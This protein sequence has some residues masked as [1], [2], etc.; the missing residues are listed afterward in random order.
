MAIH[1]NDSYLKGVI[2]E[3]EYKGLAPLVKTCHEELHQKT[4][5]GNDFLGWIDL[6][7]DYDKEEFARIKAAAKRINEQ[8]DILIVL[9]IGGSYLGARAAIELLRSPF[10]NSLKKDTVDIYFAGNSVSATYLQELL[11]ICEGKDLAVN[12]VSKSGTTTETA[13]AF[14]IFKQLLEEKYGVEGAKSRIYCTTDKANGKL[15][16][17]ADENGY[18][19]F[20]IPDDAGGRFSVLTAVGLLPIAAAGCDLDAIMKGAADARKDFLEPDLEKNDCY[21]YAATRFALYQKQKKMEIMVS[22]EPCFATMA[23]WYKQLFGESEGKDNKGLYPSSVTFSTDLHSLGQFIQE[24]SRIMFETF[25]D[26]KK[27]KQDMYIQPDSTNFD[28][29]NFLA[30]QNMSVVNKTVMDATILAHSE[31]GVPCVVLEMPEINEYEMGYMIYF[32]EKACGISAYLLGVNPFNQ[33]GVESYKTNM[34]ALLGKPGYEDLQADLK[35]KL[36]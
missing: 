7:V 2:S 27:P 35:A 12:C 30:D 31:G 34:F 21:K 20:V 26:I 1:F 23:E 36:S 16:E 5:L 10:Y 25:M 29:L 15:K 28:G 13:L 22:F 24:G 32:F 14:R 6:P 33:P 19:C 18:E 3:D 8:A 9:G 4:G 11:S 17:L